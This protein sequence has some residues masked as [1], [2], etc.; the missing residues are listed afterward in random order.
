MFQRLK[1]INARQ[2]LIG[3]AVVVVVLFIGKMVIEQVQEQPDYGKYQAV[4]LTNGQV[5]FGKLSG[6]GGDYVT[7]TDAYQVQSQGNVA[8]PSPAPDAQSR[9]TLAR[10]DQNDLTRPEQ[11]MTIAK[12]SV[13]FWENMQDDAE[14]VKKIDE[15]KSK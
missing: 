15:L 9:L 6:L 13:L 8:N 12:T 10:I 14:V 5:Y 2:W 11:K 3:L 4:F 1:V 7:L